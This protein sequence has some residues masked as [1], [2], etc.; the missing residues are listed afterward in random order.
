[1]TC[2]S[3]KAPQAKFLSLIT[4]MYSVSVTFLIILIMYVEIVYFGGNKKLKKKKPIKLKVL[5][6]SKDWQ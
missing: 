2:P 3:E 1:M 6:L 5:P 4:K